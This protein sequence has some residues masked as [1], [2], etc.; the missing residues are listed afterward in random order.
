MDPFL[1]VK[2][3]TLTTSLQR[4]ASWSYVQNITE[5]KEGT[6]TQCASLAADERN[7]SRNA[8]VQETRKV[9]RRLLHS[10]FSVVARDLQ[11]S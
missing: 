5:L 7:K 11:A 8:T 3:F 2:G 4:M 6:K 1:V 9:C 10:L